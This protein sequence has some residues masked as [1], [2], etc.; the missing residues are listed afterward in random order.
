ASSDAFVHANDREP[1]GLIALEALASGLPMVGVRSGGVA[2]SVDA[3]V[4]QLAE[5]ATAAA[6]AEAVEAL[7]ARD[8][9]A[10]AAAARRRAVER[11]GWARTF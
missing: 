1:F 7:F 11:H 6:M 2:E 5:R 8:I 4:G 9:E 10:V 3:E